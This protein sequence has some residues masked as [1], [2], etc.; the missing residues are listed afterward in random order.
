MR[1]LQSSSCLNACC[2]N[3][4]LLN[5]VG[6]LVNIGVGKKISS[7]YEQLDPFNYWLLNK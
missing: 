3:M 4:L 6:D 7:P 5:Q 1:F 2:G